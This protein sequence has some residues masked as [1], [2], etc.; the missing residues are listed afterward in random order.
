MLHFGYISVVLTIVRHM[1][2][3]LDSEEIGRSGHVSSFAQI[4]SGYALR[5]LRLSTLTEK[6]RPAGLGFPREF[7]WSLE[8]EHELN[9]LKIQ[10]VISTALFL[11]AYI[12]DYV[13]RNGNEDLAMRLDKC[14]PP[15][16]FILATE[17]LW[18]NSIKPSEEPYG[19]IKRLFSVRNKLVHAKSKVGGSIFETPATVGELLPTDNIDLLLEVLKKFSLFDSGDEVTDLILRQVKAWLQ[20]AASD[21][22]FYPIPNNA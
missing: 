19:S 9:G 15:S 1:T 21:L 20:V 5:F 14:D 8:I 13:A 11:E 3:D 7:T 2:K 18:K 6:D 16:K 12:F 10:S 17:I 4:V 22:D